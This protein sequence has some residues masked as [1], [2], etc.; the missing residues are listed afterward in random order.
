MR[1]SKAIKLVEYLAKGKVSMAVTGYPGSGKM[2]MLKMIAEFV[3]AEWM[4]RVIECSS[5]SPL[6]QQLQESWPE[7]NITLASVTA[8]VATNEPAGS[9]SDNDTVVTIITAIASDDLAV[10]AITTSSTVPGSTVFSH[11]ARSTDDL[12]RSLRNSLLAS[13]ALS[14]VSMAEEQVANAVQIDIH[15]CSRDGKCFIERITEICTKG[16]C[17]GCTYEPHT[18]LYYDNNSGSY[19]VGRK[20]SDSLYAKVADALPLVEQNAFKEFIRSL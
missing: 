11:H 19:K 17:S 15:M 3:P 9:F 14:D 12:V 1:D 4:L 7:R 2:T 16:I 10:T 6:A 20:M 18:L 8:G 13:G 5:A